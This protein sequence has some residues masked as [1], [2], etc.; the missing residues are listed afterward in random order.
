MAGVE[1]YD[2]GIG[3]AIPMEHIQGV[4]PR[5]K[6]GEDLH[7]GLA[8]LS[9][10]GANLYTGEPIV[11]ACRPGAPA[12]AAGLKPG[13]RIVEIDGRRVARAADVKEEIGRRYA[14]Q[15]MRVVVLRGK[16]RV[17]CPIELAAKL[18]PFQHGFLGILPMRTAESD[19]VRVRYV[20]PESPAA[21]AGITAGET[22]VS[23]QGE[24]IANAAELRLKLGALE[25][26]TEVELEVSGQVGNPSPVKKVKL[27]MAQLPENLPAAEL[28]PSRGESEK[29]D[30]DRPKVGA[31]RLK[32]PEFPHEVWA[33]VPEGYNAQTPYGVVVWLHGPGGFDWP[34]LLARWK[35]LCDRCDLILVAPKS[36]AAWTPGE[37]SLVDRLLEQVAATYHVDSARVVVHGYQA[38]GTLAFQAAYRNRDLVAAVAVVEAA[39]TAQPPENDPLSRLAVYLATAG[40]SPLARPAASA[41]AALRQA[42]IPVTV[43]DLGDVPRYLNPDELAELVRWIDTLDRI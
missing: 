9:L 31:I 13:D 2:S 28:P 33:Y 32:V 5:L 7:P 19:G 26:A 21:A 24:P 37:A 11:A 14:G 20:Y 40:K 22:I 39:P 25:P 3:F 34:E 41:L 23:L 42:K 27:A 10:K 30:G 36:T 8:G 17:E 1:W 4:L 18:A 29:E 43:K 15:K 38:G 6:K 12:A 16:D 35:P